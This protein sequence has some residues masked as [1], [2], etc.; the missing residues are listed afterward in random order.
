MG[1]IVI[2]TL[3]VV[4]II[5]SDGDMDSWYGFMVL[6]GSNDSEDIGFNLW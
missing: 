4:K 6:I 5:L 3:V 2:D 1:L